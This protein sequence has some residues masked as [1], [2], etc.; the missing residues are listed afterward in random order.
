MY[1]VVAICPVSN[2]T[3]SELHKFLELAETALKQ[4]EALDMKVHIENTDDD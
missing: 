2:R 4:Y 3:Y 1:R